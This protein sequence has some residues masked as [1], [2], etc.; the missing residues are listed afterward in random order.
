[1]VGRWTRGSTT[2][3]PRV[4]LQEKA[5]QK[6]KNYQ[7]NP[8]GFLHLVAGELVGKSWSCGCMRNEA[9]LG[10]PVI[11][12]KHG[13][14]AT[15]EAGERRGYNY[16]A[17]VRVIEGVVCHSERLCHFVHWDLSPIY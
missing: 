8:E 17:K 6:G 12:K 14:R 2:D 13:D 3:A 11:S 5:L 16:S 15:P 4:P 9:K 10:L 7:T 1:M